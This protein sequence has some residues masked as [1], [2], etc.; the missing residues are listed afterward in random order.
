MRQSP[1]RPSLL[2]LPCPLEDSRAANVLME[3][4]FF[5]RPAVP[6]IRLAAKNIEQNAGIVYLKGNVEI[7]LL[8]HVLVADEADYDQDSGEIQAR[9]KVRLTPA[10]LNPRGASQFGIK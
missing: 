10:K 3:L 9:G 8:T 7:N 5:G 6:T 4:D 2:P 1:P